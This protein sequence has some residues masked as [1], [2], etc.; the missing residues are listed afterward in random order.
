MLRDIKLSVQAFEETDMAPLV[1][2]SYM[3]FA[4]GAAISS[5]DETG[6][7]FLEVSNDGSVWFDIALFN[8]TKVMKDMAAPYKYIRLRCSDAQTTGQIEAVIL[9][10][11]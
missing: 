4:A 11:G 7:A 10:Q 5:T 1:T 3:P 8:G 2:T 6:Q 9:V